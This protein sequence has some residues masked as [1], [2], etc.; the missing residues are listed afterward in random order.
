M[1]KKLSDKELATARNYRGTIRIVGQWTIEKHSNRNNRTGMECPTMRTWYG[2]STKYTHY[3]SY[4]TVQ[5]R[6]E[7]I[8]NLVLQE[9]EAI[10]TRE[11]QEAKNK[12]AKGNFVNPYMIGHVFSN[13]WGYDQTNVD[14]YEVIAKT[15]WTVTIREIGQNSCETGF[16]QGKCQPVRGKYTGPAKVKRIQLDGNGKPYVPCKYGWI[17]DWDGKADHWTAYA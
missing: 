9:R 1:S 14:Y 3:Y 15:D 5:K 11:A 8:D 13:S 17:S 16:M 6:D 12:D 10:K 4:L 7:A 2:R